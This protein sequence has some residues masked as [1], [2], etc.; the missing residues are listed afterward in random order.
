MTVVAGPGAAS[1]TALADETIAPLAT[2]LAPQALPW[3]AIAA[4][5]TGAPTQWPLLLVRLLASCEENRLEVTVTID[6][7][8]YVAVFATWT[9]A[10]SQV[11]VHAPACDAEGT[12]A[13]F[14]GKV[15]VARVTPDGARTALAA[16]DVSGAVALDLVQGLLGRVMAVAT[17]EKPRLRRQAQELRSMRRLRFARDSVL[18]RYGDDLGAPRLADMLTWDAATGQLDTSPLPGGRE[19]DESYRPRLRVLRTPRLLTPTWLDAQV[20]GFTDSG[21]DRPGWMSDVG[22]GGRVTADE[23]SNPLYVA[24]RVLAPGRGE[25]RAMLLDAVRRTHLVWRSGQPGDD[26]HKA[27]ML[28]P[29]TTQSITGARAALTTLAAPADEPVALPLALALERLLALQ[30]RLGATPFTKMLVGQRD[31]GGSRYELGHGAQLAAPV[32]AELAKAV[33]QAQVAQDPAIVAQPVADDPVGAWLLR[34]AG[35][36]TAHALSDGTVFVSALTTGSLVVDL[37]PDPDSATPLQLSARLESATDSDHEE[38]LQAVVTTLAASPLALAPVGDTATLLAG[39]KPS[40]DDAA[41][42]AALRSL[43]L[44]EVLDVAD[45][46]SRMAAIDPR[47]Y[48]V[49]DLGGETGAVTGDPSRL[50]E[51]LGELAAAGVS[52]ALPL[53]T[54]SDTL[55]LALGVVDLPVAGNNLA[56]QHTIAYR[57]H[58]RGLAGDPATLDLGRG[59]KVTVVDGGRGLGIAVCTAY[60]RTGGNDPY[61]WTPTL[62]DGSLLTLRQYEHLMNVVELVTPLGV[63]ADTWAIRRR[64][65]DVDGSGAPTP[66]APSAAR[67]YHRYRP[68]R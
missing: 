55:A 47:Q 3:T 52:S 30:D 12:A 65:V 36:R 51:L 23:T 21:L 35:M 38:P 31:D 9:E 61:Q 56:S 18:D 67:T 62:P 37:T 44:P 5:D 25:G 16:A 57:W 41:L 45:L 2:S 58:V 63:R 43:D 54:A 14:A 49:A 60:V 20:N 24:F 4:F 8:P 1:L 15:A 48:V 19:T 6:G 10:A 34:A 42:L 46:Q 27:R 28:P 11:P 22:F 26:I 53:L 33:D 39:V 32:A 7:T 64:H 66:L 13:A 40:A 68:F 59:P 29:A 17:S 50:A